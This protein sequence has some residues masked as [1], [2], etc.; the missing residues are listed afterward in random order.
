MSVHIRKGLNRDFFP[1]GVPTP[2]TPE[3]DF[4]DPNTVWVWI[5]YNIQI[6]LTRDTVVEIMEG[7]DEQ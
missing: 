6:E 7:F 3:L 1:D 4:R 5:A 2:E